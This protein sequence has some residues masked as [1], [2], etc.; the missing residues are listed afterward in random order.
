MDRRRFIKICAGSA[1]ALSLGIHRVWAANYRDYS[2]ALFTD[3][4]GVPIKVSTLGTEEAYLFHYPYKGLPC[5][6]INLGKP[7][8]ANL[9]LQS[10]PLG[11]D[12]G[13]YNWPGGVGKTSSLVAYVAV[14]THQLSAPNTNASYMRYAASG[15]E[16]AGA[17]GKIVCCAHGT[18]FD[19][20]KGA[21]R[22]S[23]PATYPLLPIRLEY[24]PADDS[25]A[26]TGMAGHQLIDQYFK[27]YKRDLIQEFGAGMYRESVGANT[28]T[29]LLSQYSASIPAC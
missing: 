2:R 28:I 20:A 11:E 16:L 13:S 27:S 10:D 4:Q 18:V 19:P 23:G 24:D 15:S 12:S 25:L 21:E 1:A 8:A 6:L 9:T 22:V 26:A 5:F 7:A 3:T 17:P 14:C 29:Q